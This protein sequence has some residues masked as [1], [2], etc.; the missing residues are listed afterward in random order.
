DGWRVHGIRPAHELHVSAAFLVD[1]TGPSGLLPRTLGIDTGPVV[2]RTNSWS[3]YC[4]FVDVGWWR[5]GLLELGATVADHPYHCDHA[6]LHHV[7]EDGWV[8]V[9]R[10]NNGV[11]S[12][13]V[14]YDGERRSPDSSVAAE[15]EW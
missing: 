7:L 11:T 15:A 6:A 1:A 13:G 12:A 14:M 5:D 3:V 4:H 10:F 9:L 8:W 2:V